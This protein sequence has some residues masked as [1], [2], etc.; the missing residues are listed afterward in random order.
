MARYDKAIIFKDQ[1]GKEYLSRT[2]YPS[3]PTSDTDILITGRYGD[4]FTNLSYQFYETTE[5]WWVIARANNQNNGSMYL[6][7]GKRYRIPTDISDIM[8]DFDQ[9]NN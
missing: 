8:L 5:L 4:T 6:E 9:I 2:R 3:I 1:T 7:I